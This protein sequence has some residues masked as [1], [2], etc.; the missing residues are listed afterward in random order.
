[1]FPELNQ[2]ALSETL[3]A[4]ENNVERAAAVIL[5]HPD[6]GSSAF[7]ETSSTKLKPSGEVSDDVRRLLH[8]FP[9]AD[10]SMLK[11]ALER[12]GGDISGAVAWLMGEGDPRPR[13]VSIPAPATVT[14]KGVVV[15]INRETPCQSFLNL[16]VLYKLYFSYS[17]RKIQLNLS[18]LAC[19]QRKLSFVLT[20]LVP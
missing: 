11:T 18:L 19:L 10:V 12:A 17:T 7:P 2:E 4:C 8:I 1:M 15:R 9:K 20:V 14:T 6:P 16:R 13:D 5:G 3:A